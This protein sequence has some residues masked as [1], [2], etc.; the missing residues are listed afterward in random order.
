ML[1]PFSFMTALFVG[2]PMKTFS[3]FVLGILLFMRPVV[4]IAGVPQDQLRQSVDKLVAIL[5]D[6]GLKKEDK[7]NERREKLKEVIYQRFDFTEMAKRALGPHWQQRSPAEQQE[8]VKLFTG[9][10]ENAYLDKI[11]SYNGEKVQYLNETADNNYTEVDTK[12]VG[13]NGQEFS[14][15]YRLSNENGEWKVY[16]VIIENIGLVHNYRSQFDRVLAKSSFEELLQ[17]M[18]EKGFG[19]AGK[20]S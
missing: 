13:S 18:R 7:K 6:P 5:N 10:L 16:D 19:T 20:K 4:V 12:I 8:F 1:Q 15:N 14:V 17:T 3:V 9:L 2:R 11:E